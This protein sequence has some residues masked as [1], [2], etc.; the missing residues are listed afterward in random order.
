MDSVFEFFKENPGAKYALIA[1]GV[2][3]AMHFAYSFLK[4]TQ[5]R[6]IKH[7]SLGE[8]LFATLFRQQYQE[9]QA[10]AALKR[11]NFHQAGKLYEEMAKPSKAVAA[12]E[13]GQLY[14]EMGDLYQR[15]GRDTDAIE[16]YK[17]G[18]HLENVIK[19]YIKRKNVE[20]AGALLENNNRYQEAAELYL[21]NNRLDK[22]AQIY[23]QKGFFKKAAQIYEK[24]DNLKKA[25]ANYERWYISNADT[26]VGYQN[27]SESEK[28]LLKAAELY[29]R[30]GEN[31]KAFDLLIRYQKFEGAAEIAEKT[32]D[33]LKAAE[34][35]EKAHRT[36]K[37]ADLYEKAGKKRIAFQLR[38]EESFAKGQ[39]SEAASWFLKGEDYPRAAE[40]YEWEKQFDKAAHCYFMNHN[41][42][43]AAEN[44][45][46]A[47]NEEEAAKM[48]E[49]GQEWKMAADISF[50]FKK[51]QKAGELFEKS[52]D[53]YNAGVSF[54][55]VDDDKRALTNFQLVDEGDEHFKNA[56][57]QMA[58]IF[59]KN[60]R[61]ELVIEKLSKL[62]KDQPINKE[63]ID[64]Y[65]AIGQAFENAGHF[66]KAFDIYQGILSEDYA[67][68]DVHD[69]LKEIEKLIQKYKEMELVKDNESQ[70]YKILKKAGEGG[71]G[72]VYK[73]EDTVLKRIVALKILNNT[74]IKDK[75]SLE[76][77]YTEARSTASLSHA[78]IVTVYDVGQMNNDH[79]I[80]MEF[81]EGEN[82]MSLIKRKQL[83]SVPQL[84][85]IMIKVLK[86]L[87][88]SHR[89]GI[90][91]RDIKPHNIMITKQK[92]IKIMDFGLAVIRGDF[93][94]GETGVITGTPYYMS[95][96]QIQG[97]KVDH[98]TDIY[99]TGA[100]MFHL[101][102]G[103]VPFKGENIFY[104]HL[105]EPLPNIHELRKD[106][107]EKLIG[108]IEKCM[109]KKRENRFQSAQDVL[110]EIKTIKT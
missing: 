106:L 25:A 68:R 98:R 76:R 22:A 8:A 91:H 21:G 87:D 40:L 42:L 109:E 101:G 104:Q 28:D 19:I 107:P 84:L 100:T 23:E 103:R 54:L 110:N 82:F 38:G 17:K 93:K 2:I 94:K 36:S 60:R 32:G 11:G 88:Y 48:F 108:I 4:A 86:A 46:K 96:E 26:S 90:I 97:I 50:K 5:L 77:F 18:G 12:Y 24:D 29:E 37:A 56:I 105:F 102:T 72:V 16:A 52:Q 34:L 13:E 49:L 74:L 85:F 39:T 45:M 80:S 62:L 15:L 75:R 20:A 63:N 1:T 99:S 79:F 35:Y 64:W 71:M 10:K 58:N 95:P 73:A 6:K 65:Y 33:H 27:F 30:L 41:Y 44:Y 57:S 78:N 59:L 89:K 66:K 69:K 14:F 83:F 61:P 7:K 3:L 9:R 53:F 70:R 51:Y 43:A 31:S 55:R 81:I 47:G 67:Y 92:E